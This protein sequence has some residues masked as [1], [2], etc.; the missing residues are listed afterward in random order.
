MRN[1]QEMLVAEAISNVKHALF[2][3]SATIISKGEELNI[4]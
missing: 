1:I 2:V 3:H 4:M